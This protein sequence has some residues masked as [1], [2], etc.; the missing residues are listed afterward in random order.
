MRQLYLNVFPWWRRVALRR[1]IRNLRALTWWINTSLSNYRGLEV[2][3]VKRK[4]SDSSTRN[5]TYSYAI[6]DY[7][8]F[9][10]GQPSAPITRDAKGSGNSGTDFFILLWK[11]LLW[12]DKFQQGELTPV[13]NYVLLTHNNNA[14]YLS[15]EGDQ[16]WK[17]VAACLSRYQTQRDHGSF[18][19]KTWI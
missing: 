17:E 3:G 12:T 19:M 6:A 5:K 1:L 2:V 7:G 4:Q 8:K 15:I 14:L 9:M 18:F 13:V 10:D 16:R 11:R